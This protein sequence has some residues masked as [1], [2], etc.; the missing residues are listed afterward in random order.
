MINP[1]KDLDRKTVRSRLIGLI[2]KFSDEQLLVALRKVEELPFKANRKELRKRY[3]QS[4]EFVY[5]KRQ[6]E[7]VIHDIS[8]S[9]VFIETGSDLSIGG[10][11]QLDFSFQGIDNHIRITGKIVRKT[12]RGIGIKFINLSK[13]QEDIIRNLVDSC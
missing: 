11:I 2:D 5:Q 13:I 10:D 6:A 3:F 8:Y 4:I 1:D 12:P 9:G 7:G